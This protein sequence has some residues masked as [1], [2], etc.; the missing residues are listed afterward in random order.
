MQKKRITFI[1]PN[2]IYIKRKRRLRIEPTI[3]SK[4]KWLTPDDFE[5]EL[6]DARMEDVD[7]DIKTD[8]VV[9]SVSTLTSRS[10]YSISA[11]FRRRGIPVVLGGCHVTLCPEEAMENADAVCLGESEITWP[12]VLEDFKNNNLQKIYKCDGA[13]YDFHEVKA[14]RSIYKRYKYVPISSIEFSRGCKF[15]CEF[16]SYAPIYKQQVTYRNPEDVAIEIKSN[17][18]KFFLF[19]DENFGNDIE[20][21]SKLCEALMPLKIKW[22]AQ[23]SVNALQNADFVKLLA[24]SGCK[25]LFIGFET[26]NVETLKQMNKMA[27]MKKDSYDIAIQNCVDNDIAIAAGL[28]VG[29]DTDTRESINETYDFV[30]KHQI[31]FCNFVNLLPFP[32]TPFYNR[33]KESGR[34]IF[35]KW[36]LEDIAPYHTALFVTEHFN[37]EEMTTLGYDYIKKYYSYRE[38]FKRFIHSR[39]KLPVRI[40]ILLGNIFLKYYYIDL[41]A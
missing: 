23:M 29:S 39:Y 30:S 3:Y 12:K 2:L 6:I 1:Q 33:L 18:N 28:I 36:W 31:L 9:M 14:D 17:P 34:L 15:N 41:T 25:C 37:K 40:M 8:L 26:T 11:E 4:L 21:T 5:C 22:F 20:Q 32:G 35:D 16:C 7:F 24:K 27:N 19:V 10:A 13:R 38:M